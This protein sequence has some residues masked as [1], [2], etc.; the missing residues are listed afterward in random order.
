VTQPRIQPKPTV[1]PV[2]VS[3]P[4][5]RGLETAGGECEEFFLGTLEEAL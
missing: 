2:T 4:E 1:E 5:L 3:L